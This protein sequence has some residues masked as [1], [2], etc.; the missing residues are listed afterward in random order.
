MYPGL[1]TLMGNNELITIQK[2]TK[3]VIGN[4]PSGAKKSYL[5]TTSQSI[6]FPSVFDVKKTR[7]DYCFCQSW[8]SWN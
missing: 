1:Q 6:G 8:K 2:S 5:E 4:N 3:E 7:R